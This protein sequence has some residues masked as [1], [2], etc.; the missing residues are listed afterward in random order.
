V[1]V[2]SRIFY[3]SNNKKKDN[4]EKNNV[5]A[6]LFNYFTYREMTRKDTRMLT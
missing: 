6:L 2:D 4:A 3:I 1:N 5:I